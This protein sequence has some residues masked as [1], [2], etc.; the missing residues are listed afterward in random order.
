MYISSDGSRRTFLENLLSSWAPRA[1]ALVVRGWNS[2][3]ILHSEKLMRRIGECSSTS[4]LRFLDEISTIK[5]V[6]LDGSTRLSQGMLYF[7]DPDGWPRAAIVTNNKLSI[8]K[9]TLSLSRYRDRPATWQNRNAGKR[10]PDTIQLDVQRL[11]SLVD[12]YFCIDVIFHRNALL[13]TATT[14]I[15]FSDLRTR[16]NRPSLKTLPYKE[17][18]SRQVP[19]CEGGALMVHGGAVRASWVKISLFLTQNASSLSLSFRGGRWTS[20]PFF[21]FINTLMCKV[22][23][24]VLFYL[25]DF[26]KILELHQRGNLG[27][28]EQDIHSVVRVERKGR[29]GV[30]LLVDRHLPRFQ[31][32]LKLFCDQAV[33][34]CSNNC[35]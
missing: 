30:R 32:V 6:S 20:F 27:W 18:D 8:E 16:S 9:T 19:N 12:L 22:I 26:G 7:D 21:Q 34:G 35:I 25:S 31:Q 33:S 14:T 5:V 3:T 13:A 2:M 28:R 11:A 15:D 4:F 1:K 10:L 29:M 24:H 17:A 23:E